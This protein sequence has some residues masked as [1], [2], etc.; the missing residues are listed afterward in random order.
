MLLDIIPI[1]D[2]LL[3]AIRLGESALCL[4]FEREGEKYEMEIEGLVGLYVKN[5]LYGNIVFSCYIYSIP[6]NADDVSS[7]GNLVKE[8]CEFYKDPNM[9]SESGKVIIIASSYGAELMAT[10]TGQHVHKNLSGK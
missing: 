10:F 6:I 7:I 8:Y 4:S 3:T 5:F 2:S 1:H 9:L